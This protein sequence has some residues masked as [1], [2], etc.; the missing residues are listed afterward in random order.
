MTLPGFLFGELRHVS[1]VRSFP[2]SVPS[3]FVV[4]GEQM[5]HVDDKGHFLLPGRNFY[6]MVDLDWNQG[7]G[8]MIT[9]FNGSYG[10]LSSLQCFHAT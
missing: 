9:S 5:S 6:Y 7:W 2:L 10:F 8:P 4:C 1:V 3:V